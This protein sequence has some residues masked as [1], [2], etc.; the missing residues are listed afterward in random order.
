MRR[1]R[2]RRNPNALRTDTQRAEDQL[3]GF[4]SREVHEDRQHYV[5]PASF[6]AYRWQTA[7]YTADAVQVFYVK[8]QGDNGLAGLGAASVMPKEDATFRPGID[9]LESVTQKSF[10]GR[11]ALDFDSLMIDLERRVPGYPRHLVA[12]EMAL[13]DLAA[14]ADKVSLS[15]FLGGRHHE[16][17]PVLKMLGMG[18][19]EF[20]ADR[21]AQF[22]EQGYHFLKIKLGAG[23]ATDLERFKAVREAAGNGVNFTADFNGAYDATTAIRVIDRLTPDGLTMV[24]QPVPADDITGMALVNKA[25]TPLV[26]ADQSVNTPEDVAKIADSR[27]AKAVSIKLLKLGGIRKSQAVVKACESMGLA[28]HVGGTGTTRLVEAAQAHFISAT[29][30]IIVPSEI[31]EFEELDGDLVDGFEVV[32]GVIRVPDDPG[33]GVG[34]AI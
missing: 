23:P 6:E 10:V 8:L 25:V 27:A 19:T 28:C 1:S 33:L 12:V 11:D 16:S 13:L 15:T 29:P 32:N 18:S 20:M 22:V 31:A 9:A 3:N 2:R 26:L 7:S 5:F 14:K 21:A 17:I 30:G 24:E 4:G 34:L